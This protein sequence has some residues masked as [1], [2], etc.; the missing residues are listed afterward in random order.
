MTTTNTMRQWWTAYRC[1]TD[2]PEIDL[3]GRHAGTVPGIAY[4]GFKALEVALLA[5]GYLGVQSVWI[6]RP[7]SAGGIGGQTCKPDGSG[8]SLHNYR[9]AVDIDPFGYGNPY[10]RYSSGKG[11]PYSAGLWDFSDTKI[12]RPQVEAVEAIRNTDGEVYFR[13]LGWAIGDSMHFEFQVPPSRT[14]VDWTSVP[15]IGAAMLYGYDIGVVGEPSKPEDPRG[16]VLQAFL[17]RQGF[18]LGTW[19]PNNDGVDRRP[20]DD[21][22]KA[23]HD[24]KLSVGITNQFSAGDGKI[25]DYEL[26][27]IYAAGGNVSHNHDGRYSRSGHSHDNRYPRIGVPRE[28]EV[29]FK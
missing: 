1:D 5:S 17:V 15:N 22:R 2:G 6:P 13:W 16:G 4:D 29:E 24:W 18:D 20:G 25:G 21:T 23:L 8:C 19:G 14:N 27:A 9:I 3:F 7:C 12:T 28:A 11:I 26:A 10:F